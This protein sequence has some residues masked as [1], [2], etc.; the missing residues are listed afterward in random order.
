MGRRCGHRTQD[1]SDQKTDLECRCYDSNRHCDGP[2]SII[3][4]NSHDDGSKDC[5]TDRL[6]KDKSVS[7]KR[8][9]SA[10]PMRR[11]MQPTSAMGPSSLR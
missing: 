11:A 3:A 9:L 2:D 6:D 7:L 5:S 8:K 4:P 1:D 10:A